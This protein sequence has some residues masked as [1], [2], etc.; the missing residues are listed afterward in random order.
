MARKKKDT[1]LGTAVSTA[2]G[3]VVVSNLPNPTGSSAVTTIKQRGVE[4]FGKASSVFP[5]V[6]K[7]KG[8]GMV[9]RQT[10]RLTKK[11]RRIV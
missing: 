8:V 3:A 1:L 2:T 6:G 5:A 10:K 7:L 9:L 11:S 4:G